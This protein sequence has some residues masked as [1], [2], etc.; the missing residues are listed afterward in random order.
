LS[1]PCYNRQCRKGAQK[2]FGTKDEKIKRGP[3]LKRWPSSISSKHILDVPHE[4]LGVDD[5]KVM[6]QITNES[7][8]VLSIDQ[9]TRTTIGNIGETNLQVLT[10]FDHV[11][12]W[13]NKGEENIKRVQF[14]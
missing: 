4:Q 8:L 9:D 13:D 12:K 14:F 5:P 10:S 2:K 3:S 1:E 11:E 7:K 6:K